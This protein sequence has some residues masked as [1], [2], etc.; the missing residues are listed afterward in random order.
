MGRHAADRQKAR[1]AKAL[2]RK[3]VSLDEIATTVGLGRSTVHRIVEAIPA[4]ARA[5]ANKARAGVPPTWL[6]EARQ[7]IAGGMTRNEAA[8]ALGVPKS[9]VYRVL[10]RF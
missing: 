1:Q 3:C 2:R 6:L 8:A 10:Q 7:L 5:K 4:D 9:T